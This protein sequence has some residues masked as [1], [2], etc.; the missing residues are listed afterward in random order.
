MYG[1]LIRRVLSLV[2]TGLGELSELVGTQL[3]GNNLLWL[4]TGLEGG[5]TGLGSSQ[6]VRAVVAT[7]ELL[8]QS[9][10]N[11]AGVGALEDD[12]LAQGLGDLAGGDVGTLVADSDAILGGNNV[13]GLQRWDRIVEAKHTI[14]L[15]LVLGEAGVLVAV[16]ASNVE[17]LGAEGASGALDEAAVEVANQFPLEINRHLAGRIRIRSIRKGV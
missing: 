5:G 6:Q 11:T 8:L 10:G 16:L 2:G 15:Y 13:Q 1:V 17:G 14:V 12:G 7:D 4:L 3:L 9:G